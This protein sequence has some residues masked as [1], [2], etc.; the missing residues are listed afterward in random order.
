MN[1]A[2][3]IVT[4]N[5]KS[6]LMN[7]I[8]KV[9]M[10]KPEAPE[11]II[12]DNASTDGTESY[13]RSLNNPQI[14]YYNTGENFGGAGGFAYGLEKACLLGF[15][16]C[17]I[18]DDDTYPQEDAFQSLYVKIQEIDASYVCSRVMWT[19]GNV[20]SMNTPPTAKRGCFNNPKALN[21]HLMEIQG[22]SFVSCMVNMKYMKQVGLPIAEFFIYGDDVEFTRRLET[23]S[24][25]YLDLDSVVIHAMPNN[26]V[27]SIV[28]CETDRIERYRYGVR[29]NVYIQRHIDH[30]SVMTVFMSMLRSVIVII[31]NSKEHK[32]KRLKIL[33][34]STWKG[35]FFHPV[36]K[37]VEKCV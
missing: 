6:M 26:N 3:V 25:G 2:A 35:L 29:N 18:M 28:N 13:I 23:K 17:W 33:I 5:R 22:C 14:H 36:I 10:Q 20:C 1:S 15:D 4:Y 19:D 34:S 24:K 27:A 8:A 12:I 30:A 37:F 11:V 16:Y 31:V 7:C 9:L 21:L 32:L